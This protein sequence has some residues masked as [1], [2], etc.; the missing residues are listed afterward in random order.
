MKTSDAKAKAGVGDMSHWY[1]AKAKIRSPS[2]QK[3]T[4]HTHTYI[5]IYIY[6]EREREREREFLFECGCNLFSLIGEASAI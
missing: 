3:G 4:S 1:T 6:I 5:Y 2:F